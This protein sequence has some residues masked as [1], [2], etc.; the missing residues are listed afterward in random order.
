MLALIKHKHVNSN[1]SYS[2]SFMVYESSSSTKEIYDIICQYSPAAPR[3][4]EK[5]NQ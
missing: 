1:M 5:H 2:G 4:L 3:F